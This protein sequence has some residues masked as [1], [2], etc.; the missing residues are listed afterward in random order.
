[1]KAL[2]SA[3][4]GVVQLRKLPL[5][6]ARRQRNFDL[7]SAFFGNYPDV[8][9]LP[10]QTEE[11]ETGWHMF[12][13]LIRPESGIRRAEFQEH[14][15][16]HGVDTSA[17]R[18]SSVHHTGRFISTTDADLN[19]FAAFYPGAMTEDTDIDLGELAGLVDLVLVHPADTARPHGSEAWLDVAKPA[20]LFHVRR[21]HEGD[22]QRM[23]RVLTGQSVGLVL[24]GGGARAYAHVG[25]IKALRERG[26]PIVISSDSHSRH[27]FGYLRW[28]AAVARRA[29][30]QPADVL[31]TRPF[32]EF[33]ASLRR[34]R[35]PR[36]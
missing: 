23:A 15:E 18:E 7:L 26:V 13:V 5:N 12:P 6:L 30:L 10:R 25:A 36:S 17:V 20:R 21:E 9:V 24:S 1:M 8:F 4:F 2:R 22:I 3:A 14:M 29:W 32:D 11:L 31:N 34:H 28:G 19:H 35:R 33:R 16:A 27:G